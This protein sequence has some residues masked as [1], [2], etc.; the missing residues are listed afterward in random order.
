MDDNGEAIRKLIAK[1]K[2]ENFR[3]SMLFDMSPEPNPQAVGAGE[4]R[5][6]TEAEKKNLDGK[7]I[8][9]KDSF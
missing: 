9:N 6:L 3:P 4:A 8:Y 5:S 1:D 7:E 2:D